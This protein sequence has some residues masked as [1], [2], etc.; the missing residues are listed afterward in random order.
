MKPPIRKKQYRAKNRLAATGACLG[1]IAGTGLSAHAQSDTNSVAIAQ[2]EQQNQALQQQLNTL[3]DMAKKAGIMPSGASADPPVSAM[4]NFSLSGFVQTSYFYNAER[5]AGG[6]SAGYLWNTKDNNFSLN[7]VKITLASPPAE[8]SGDEWSA[9]YRVSLMAGEDAPVL[10]SGYGLEGGAFN[11]LREAYVDL[12]VPIGQGLNVKAGELI[13]LLNYES[14]DGGAA[15][16]NFSQGYQW[17]FTGNGPAAGVQ[18][19]YAF[20]DWLDVKFRV[21]NGLYVG[22]VSTTSNKGLMGTIGL[23]PNAKSWVNLTGFGGEGSGT[24]DV[25]GGEVLA[26]YQITD[27]LGTGFEGDYFDFLPEDESAKE[28]WSVGGWIWYD[29]TPKIGLAFRADFLDDKNGGEI[30]GALPFDPPESGIGYDDPATDMHG[31]LDSYTLT[32]NL[33]PTPNIIIQPEVRYDTTSYAGGFNG[34]DFQF[35]LGCGAS[36]LF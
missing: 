2:L 25:D 10:D 14:G 24:T 6:Y 20:T 36:Y 12:N 3:E 1:M 34:R 33:K 11:Y 9:G 5:P 17:W 30:K 7:K 29:F 26:G 28:L 23:K 4:S 27:K 21:S 15:N 13:S 8:R 16:E 18:L 32:L 22:P 31:T 35:I 19:D